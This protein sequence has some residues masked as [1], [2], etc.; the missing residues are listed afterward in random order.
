M[1]GIMV[2]GGPK[3]RT[4]SWTDCTIGIL[5][6]FLKKIN[7]INANGKK[8]S[9]FVEPFMK[10]TCVIPTAKTITVTQQSGFQFQH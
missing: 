3:W 4:D 10:L 6:F 9:K 5:P 1:V 2:L 8:C 7:V